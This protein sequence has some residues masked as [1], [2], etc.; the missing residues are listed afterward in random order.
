[1][2]AIKS[3]TDKKNKIPKKQEITIK[4]SKKFKDI[5][6]LCLQSEFLNEL[7]RMNKIK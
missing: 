3:Q 7:I 4:I 1:M 5:T 2:R 6:K